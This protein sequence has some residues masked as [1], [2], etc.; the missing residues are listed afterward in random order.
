MRSSRGAPCDAWA[1]E[2]GCVPRVY[3][4]F[5]C[6]AHITGYTRLPRVETMDQTTH[7]LSELSGL[8]AAFRAQ[9]RTVRLVVRNVDRLGL[10]HLYFG[11]G[12]LVHVEGHAG[13]PAMALR[14]LATWFHGAIRLDGVAA[15]ASP[16]GGAEALEGYLD[17]ALKELEM[18]GVVY[19]APPSVVQPSSPRMPTTSGPPR[20]ARGLPPLKGPTGG[21]RMTG[22]PATNS[23]PMPAAPMGQAQEN[24]STSEDRLTSPQWHLLALAVR[25]ITEQIGQVIGPPMSDGLLHQ[26]L[27]Q[28]AARNAFLAGLDVDQT[29][30]LHTRQDGFA[31][32]FS[33]Y[34]AAEA[35]ADLLT[36]FEA[37]CATLLGADRVREM[38]ATA[39]APLRASLAQVG[40]S[41]SED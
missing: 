28:A 2:Y 13:S 18:R 7:H 19:P 33:R 22:R 5:I 20:G 24:L 15:P 41:I 39:V 29:G 31:E 8:V 25:Q 38:I 17:L 10:L 21:P 34:T 4:V 32:R 16:A 12:R 37:D 6:G 14:D 27:A 35:I 40:L 23:G 3:G 30:W 11:A 26:A 1:T 36:A 9:G